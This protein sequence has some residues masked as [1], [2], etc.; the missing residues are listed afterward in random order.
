M[1][2]PTLSLAV[3]DKVIEPLVPDSEAL[4]VGGVGSLLDP[5]T[6]VIGVALAAL[7]SALKPYMVS[8]VRNTL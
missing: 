4:T 8:S 7:P 1:V 3:A 5:H 2:T 6:S